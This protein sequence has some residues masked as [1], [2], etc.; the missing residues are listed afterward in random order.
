[1]FYKGV[2]LLS[3]C[4]NEGWRWGVGHEIVT[5]GKKQRIKQ[6]GG[7]VESYW[8]RKENI[9]KKAGRVGW[10][11]IEAMNFNFGLAWQYQLITS[12][13]FPKDYKMY[14]SQWKLWNSREG[15]WKGQIGAA[16]LL[17]TKSISPRLQNVFVHQKWQ[18]CQENCSFHTLP[19]GFQPSAI[20]VTQKCEII[21]WKYNCSHIF[22]CK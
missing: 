6:R 16:F 21:A 10:L 22:K 20:I 4:R 19:K 17:S 3:N 2:G 14:L 7:V 11:L 1:M 12:N 8:H 9:H 5:A 15:E 13:V 18:F